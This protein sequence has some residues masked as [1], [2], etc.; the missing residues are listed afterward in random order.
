MHDAWEDWLPGF[1]FLTLQGF[2]IGLIES[3]L[4]GWYT[5]LVFMPLDQFFDRTTG[6]KNEKGNVRPVRTMTQEAGSPG[7]GTATPTARMQ[8]LREE[9]K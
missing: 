8:C 7:T 1:E 9:A 6:D 4:Y 3:N 5:A 2:I